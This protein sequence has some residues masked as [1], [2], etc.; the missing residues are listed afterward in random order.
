MVVV[1]DQ[2]L[3]VPAGGSAG[4]SNP[5]D[6]FA[7]A[8]RQLGQKLQPGLRGYWHCGQKTAERSAPQ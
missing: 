5:P 3:G 4:A 7:S 2:V 1:A 8:E 6:V